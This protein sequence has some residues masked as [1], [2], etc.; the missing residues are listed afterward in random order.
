LAKRQEARD[1]QGYYSVVRQ[2]Y[3]S[4]RQGYY[5]GGFGG[6]IPQ[7]KAPSPPKLKYETL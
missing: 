1:R 7:N 6:F 4:D 3:Y 2:G 5:S